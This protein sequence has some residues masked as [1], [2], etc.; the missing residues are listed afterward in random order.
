MPTTVPAAPT[1]RI[2]NPKVTYLPVAAA[3]GTALLVAATKFCRYAEIQ[4]CPPKTFDNNAN[5]YA[6]WGLT[7]Q[8]PD[9]GYTATHGLV[10]GVVL[11]F[12]DRNWARDRGIGVA[13]MT[14]PAGNSIA[15]TPFAKITSATATVTQVELREWS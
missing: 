14:D 15:G 6:P 9:D 1:T 13:P 7:Y 11:S 3:G 4:E 12:G 8:L 10:P 2:S 5:P